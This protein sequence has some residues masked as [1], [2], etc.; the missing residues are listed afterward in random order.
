MQL[1]LIILLKSV[2]QLNLTQRQSKVKL[3]FSNT[4]SVEMLK[5][6]TENKM[7]P[8]FKKQKLLNCGNGMKSESITFPLQN[9]FFRGFLI[10][11]SVIGNTSKG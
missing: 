8:S 7:G 10:L 1:F 5:V 2:T 6:D 3:N 9:T 4:K 11:L